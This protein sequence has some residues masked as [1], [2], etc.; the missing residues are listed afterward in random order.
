MRAAVGWK[1]R[2]GGRD[3]GSIA[4]RFGMCPTGRLIIRGREV[5]SVPLR[6]VI[7]WCAKKQVSSDAAK[8]WRV[9]LRSAH[10]DGPAVQVPPDDGQ[11]H[12]RP[13]R[14]IRE[15]VQRPPPPAF[16]QLPVDEMEELGRLE[17]CYA[18]PEVK[19][20]IDQ[21][22]EQIRKSMPGFFKQKA[23]G[24]D[25]LPGID[26]P[27]WTT[28]PRIPPRP[29]RQEFGVLCD[30]KAEVH[31]MA[32]TVFEL[33]QITDAASAN[34]SAWAK[35]IVEALEALEKTVAIQETG[36]RVAFAVAIEK[37]AQALRPAGATLI[38]G[39]GAEPQPSDLVLPQPKRL[40]V[41]Y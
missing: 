23:P 17:K 35:K 29:S 36:S 4:T 22:T 6:D 25:I 16:A 11:Y 2:H 34:A 28:M 40:T 32:T 13:P 37:L 20:R 12:P 3:R 8:R 15:T 7:L 30:L 9:I 24:Q 10:V 39:A 38:P 19:A 1:P 14:K 26:L 27:P 33:R 41:E 31:R 18:T 5:P 21:L